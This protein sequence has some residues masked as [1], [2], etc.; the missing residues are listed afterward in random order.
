MSTLLN[1]ELECAS[2]VNLSS[3]ISIQFKYWSSLE[4]HPILSLGCYVGFT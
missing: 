4:I 3:D 2:L 1:K